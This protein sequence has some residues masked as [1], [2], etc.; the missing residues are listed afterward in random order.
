MVEWVR[1]SIKSLSL[2]PEYGNLE[3][4][5]R[6]L[7]RHSGLSRSM[8]L[9]LYSGEACNPTVDALDKLVEAVKAAMRKAAA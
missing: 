2:N 7:A 6:E 1:A 3:A 4:V 5:Y 8:V 9:K